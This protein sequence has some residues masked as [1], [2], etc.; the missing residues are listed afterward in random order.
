MTLGESM[1]NGWRT[2]DGRGDGTPPEAR[3]SGLSSGAD[4]EDDMENTMTHRLARFGARIRIIDG[5]ATV[6]MC[7][8]NDNTGTRYQYRRI[9]VGSLQRRVLTCRG[10]ALS[11][12]RTHTVAELAELRA[13]RGDYHPIL[14]PLGL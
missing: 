12:W 4:M 6:E 13:V 3:A 9:G 7:D 10:M 1:A 11:D 14:D 2:I 8:P 5:V